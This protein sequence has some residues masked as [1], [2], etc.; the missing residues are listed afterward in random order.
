[1]ATPVRKLIDCKTPSLV[2]KLLVGVY[3]GSKT[4][5]ELKLILFDN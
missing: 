3:Q 2:V 5:V 4:Q 1:M